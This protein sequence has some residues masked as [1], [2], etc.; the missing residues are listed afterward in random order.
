M[1]IAFNN[2]IFFS[3]KYGGISRYFV[4]LA[5]ELTQ[6]KVEFNIIAPINKNRLLKKIP[7]NKKI[8]LYLNRYPSIKIIERLNNYLSSYFIKKFDP[9]IFHET[10]YSKFDYKDI[11]AKKIL[12]VYDLIHEKFPEY[13]SKDKT[14]LKKNINKYDHFI[15]I[16]ENT[17]KDLINFYKISPKN[18]SVIYL[19]GSH[20]RNLK[21]PSTKDKTKKRNFFLYVGSRD[22]YKNFEIIYKCFKNNKDLQ[23]FEII[24]FGGGK[25][26]TF[27]LEKFEG[28]KIKHIEGNDETL[29]D[30][31]RNAICLLL[32]SKYEGFG[33][34]ML[35]AMEL[36]CPVLSSSTE[37]LKEVGNDA[38]NYF[39]PE[40]PLDLYQ[41]IK[42]LIDD[43][44]LRA[45]L[46]DKGLNRANFFSWK[47]CSNE[48]LEV[49][50]SIL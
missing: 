39:D 42:L 41:N 40:S 44:N 38:A 26:S 11:K 35:E 20:Y 13:Y 46:I 25:F 9:N 6:A 12:T 27:E 50:N 10:Y 1:K 2:T 7:N 34:P 43:N 36:S 14:Q 19:S 4:S 48:T 45:N 24:C 32:P 33:I 15:C 3:Q 8:S 5:E 18:I 49:Y 17:K 21:I 23:D 37:A 16:S 47:K 31:Y 22:Y 28:L 30:L 29:V